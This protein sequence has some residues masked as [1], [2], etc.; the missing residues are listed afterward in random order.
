MKNRPSHRH[1]LACLSCFFL[2]QA[3]A[4]PKVLDT[5]GTAIEECAKPVKE[6]KA[7]SK[8]ESETASDPE[9]KGEE[10]EKSDEKP[11][12][13]EKEA[14]DKAKTHEAKRE[15]LYVKLNLEGV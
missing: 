3:N 12:E 4:K 8:N 10:S 9:K 5:Q 15:P 6:Q 7:D 13:S 11:K 1:A 2:V 14:E